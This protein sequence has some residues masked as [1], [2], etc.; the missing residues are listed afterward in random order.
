MSGSVLIVAGLPGVGKTTVARELATRATRGAHLD[1]DQI[2]EALILSGL[3]A[4]GQEPAEEAERQLA[5]LRRNI[6]DLARNFAEAGFDVAISDVV[7]WPEL[8]EQYRTAIGLPLRFV[9]LTATEDTI[10]RRDAARDKHVAQQWAHLREAQ[11]GFR[12]PGLRLDTTGL[13]LDET[14]DAIRARW[15]DALI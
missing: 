4:P 10:A 8:L 14:V 7:L 9:L 12:A 3:V 1:T 5:L 6:A 13:D 15:D 2:G 11:D